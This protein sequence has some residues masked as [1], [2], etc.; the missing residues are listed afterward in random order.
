MNRYSIKLSQEGISFLKRLKTNRRKADIDEQD[1]S[2]W[3]LIELIAKYF[4]LNNQEYLDLVKM[5][6]NKN[7]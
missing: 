3:R 6:M 5:E 4:K 7:V 1:A 2:Y